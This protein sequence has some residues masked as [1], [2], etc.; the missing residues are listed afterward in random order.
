MVIII[1]WKLLAINLIN[2]RQTMDPECEYS[3]SGSIVC[4]ALMR[5]IAKSFQVIIITI[6]WVPSVY[7]KIAIDYLEIY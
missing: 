6:Y 4:L 7:Y 1:T 5:L 3:H 2:A